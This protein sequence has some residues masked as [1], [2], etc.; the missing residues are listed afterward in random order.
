MIFAKETVPDGFVLVEAGTFMTG[1]PSNEP[2]RYDNETQHQVTLT[3][4][5]YMSETEVTQA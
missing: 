5:F 4:D 1:S 2:D 3:R